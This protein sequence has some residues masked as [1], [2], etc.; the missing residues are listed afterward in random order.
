MYISSNQLWSAAPGPPDDDGRK[1]LYDAILPIIYDPSNPGDI[2]LRGTEPR[3]LLIGGLV[4][5]SVF[6]PL[7]IALL[8]G[9]CLG[10]LRIKRLEWA[11]TRSEARIID[12]KRD[13]T[14]A[15]RFGRNSPVEFPWMIQADWLHPQTGAKYLLESGSIWRDPRDLVHVGGAI[16]VLI[17]YS[18]PVVCYALDTLPFGVAKQAHTASPAATTSS[19]HPPDA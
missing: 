18:R 16:D 12:I 19:S 14:Q 2:A 8:I 1:N 11:G 7:G 13:S 3:N 17:D 6:W 4:F 5:A 10:S 15:N 9:P